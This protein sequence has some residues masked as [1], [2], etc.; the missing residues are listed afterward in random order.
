MAKIKF[1]KEKLNSVIRDFCV[2][3]NVSAA[4]TDENFKIIAN[5]SEKTPRFCMEIQKSNEGLARCEC[6]D[7]SLLEKCRESRRAESHICHAGIL[8][9][10]IPIIKANKIIGYVIIG[11]TRVSEFDESKIN[12]LKADNRRMKKLYY[13]ITEYNEKQIQSMLRLAAMIVSFI[14]TNDIITAEADEFSAKADEFIEKNINSRLTVKSLCREFN[15]SKNALYEKFRSAFGS[16][17]NDYIIS[18]RLEKGKTLLLN[19]DMP[20]SRIAEECGFGSYTY[21]SKLFKCEN[22]L[23]PISYRKNHKAGM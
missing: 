3:T 22:G 2:I 11:R 18:K 6:S 20:I 8:D 12:W 21:F 1:N 14:L 19:T 5:C 16:T 7:V 9:A 10:A 4:V 15:V 17:V 13:D 23:S